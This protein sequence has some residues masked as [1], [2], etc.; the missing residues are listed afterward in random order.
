M[1]RKPRVEVAGGIHHVYAR[2]NRKQVIYVSDV[3]RMLYLDLLAQAVARQRWRCLAY[4]LMN[5]HVHLLVETPAPNLGAG[6]CRMHGLYAQTFNKRH[7][8]S[9]HLFQGRFGSV[10]VKTDAQLLQVARYIAHNPVEAG[11][12]DNPGAWPWSSHAATLGG[13]GPPWL[14]SRRLLAF[15]GAAGGEPRERYVEVVR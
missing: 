11:L 7:K 15:F 14:D 3:D 1:A 10:V 6:M 13:N 4:C 9:G 2:G 8:H 5:N 12:C